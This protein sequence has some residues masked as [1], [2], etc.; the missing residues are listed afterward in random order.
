MASTATPRRRNRNGRRLILIIGGIALAIAAIALAIA[1]LLPRPPAA[2]TLP[3]GWQA[4]EAVSGTIA[5]TV[6]ATGNVEPRAEAELRFETTGTVAEVL[7]RPGDQVEQGQPLA[8]IDTTA[9]QLQVEQAQADLRQAQADFEA[10]VAGATEAELAEARAR[11]EQA[12]SQY[13]QAA[14]TVSQ[15]D[16]SAARAD[17]ESARARLARLQSGPAG[18]ELAS[19]TERVQSAQTNLDNA[20]VSLSAAKERARLDL[21]TSANALRNAQDEFSRIYWQNRELERLPGDLPRERIDQEAQAQRAVAD[22]EAALRTAQTAYDQA[23]QEEINSLAAREAEL[24]SAVAARDRLLGGAEAD[25][26]ADARAAVQRAQASLD[27]LTGAQRQ[28]ELAAQESNIEIA[29]AGLDRLLADP[30]TSAL[31]ARE[32]AVQRAEVSV[33]S[34]ERNL[35]LGTLTAP[36]PATVARV[37]MQAG[38]PADASAIIAVADLTS[39]HIDLPV[40]ELDIAEVQQGQRVTVDLDALPGRSYGGSVS[41]I[42]PLATRSETGTTTYEVTVT[43]DEDSEGVRPGMTAVVEIITEEKQGVVLVPRRAVRAEGGQSVVYVPNPNL[44]PQP[45]IPGQTAPPPGDRREVEIGLTN[46]EFVE[47]V[48]GLSAGDTVLV[49]DVVS[50]FNPAGPP[51]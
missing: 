37:G 51:Q 8:R 10:L 3:Q 50:T 40:D 31:A 29:Q 27:Q 13:A 42:A 49:Q 20:R 22:G 34:A 19:A 43:L 48:S 45:T 21:E 39:Y 24:R 32:A 12:R 2:G 47:V 14:S 41:N 23:R 35:A 33:R 25:E 28:S 38:E 36:F 44:V 5:A 7:V 11:V 46:A 16:L 17:L 30:T 9:L 4:V 1:A 26:L 15:A 18:D 6:S